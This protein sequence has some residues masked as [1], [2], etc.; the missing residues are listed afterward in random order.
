[1]IRAHVC[2]PWSRYSPRPA[3]GWAG[4]SRRPDGRG[5]LVTYTHGETGQKQLFPLLILKENSNFSEKIVIF[6]RFG[7][8]RVSPYIHAISGFSNTLC[9][10]NV[11]K[12]LIFV[13]FCS[14]ACVGYPRD[15][16]AIPTLRQAIP[17]VKPLFSSIFLKELLKKL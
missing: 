2:E 7:L 9:M 3:V 6:G 15:E 10:G 5:W 4:L 8:G 16:R 13:N 11:K 17:T 1:M 12:L 14:T